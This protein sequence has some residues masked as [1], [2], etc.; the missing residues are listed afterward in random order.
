M[1]I[2]FLNI[3][4]CVL[5]IGLILISI[6]CSEKYPSVP[7][8]DYLAE[9][10]EIRIVNGGPNGDEVIIGEINQDTKMISFP[11]INTD[12]KNLGALK[13]D[14]TFVDGS[15]L[16]K[17]VYDFEMSETN[18]SK[19]ILIKVVNRL[20]YTY[21]NMKLRLDVPVWGA[22]FENPIGIY[23]YSAS[24]EGN[25]YPGTG[26]TTRGAG[27]DGSYVLIIDRNGPHVLKVS[28]I[29]EGNI[30]PIMLDMTGV[31][32]GTFPI[33]MGSIV[34]GKIYIS[35]LSG[36]AGS[37]LNIYYWETPTS[38]PKKIASY[39]VSNEIPGAGVR[40]GDNMSVNL[41]EKGNGYFYFG[42][43][44]SKSILRLQVSN[45]INI[46]NP[47][48]LPLSNPNTKGY[49]SM[50]NIQGTD[51]YIFSGVNQS[52]ALASET[53][54]ISFELSANSVAKEGM[55]A[56]MFEFNKQRYLIMTTTGYG[57]AS[58]V[59]PS[60]FAYNFTQGANPT[61]AFQYFEESDNKKPLVEFPLGGSGNGNPAAASGYYVSKGS[62][63][64]DEYLYI[65]GARTDSGWALLKYGIAKNDDED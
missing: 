48:V 37:P 8:S 24:N 17:D 55:E 32:G 56:R 47:N 2:N 64:N 26:A 42:D 15:S 13:I 33:N 49:M 23:N 63:G 25:V 52:V 58:T 38:S 45:W 21:Y 57:G 34:D 19:E 3:K 30:N 16:D 53:A 35:S 54:S 59:N 44:A 9:M 11:K 18:P 27:F 41:D 40:H 60:I 28:D 50:M 51:Q 22:D 1:T 6:S 61:Q 46:D 12:T 20:K 43:N 65:F 39:I 7:P 29:E 14:G 31:S 62:D 36:G 10:T 5:I 4:Y